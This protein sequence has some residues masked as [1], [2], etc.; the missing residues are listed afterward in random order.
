MEEVEEVYWKCIGMPL[1]R[2][3]IK[4][5]KLGAESTEPGNAEIAN[6]TKIVGLEFFGSTW[7]DGFLE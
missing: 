2:L 4:G 6:I 3:C 5:Q 7:S 1:A